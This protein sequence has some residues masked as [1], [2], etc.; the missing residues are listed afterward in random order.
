[1][2]ADFLNRRIIVKK[3]TKTGMKKRWSS[4]ATIDGD[5]Q[6]DEDRERQQAGA[7]YQERFLGFFDISDVGLL[8]QGRLL[9]DKLT[10]T[11]YTIDFAMAQRHP[12]TGTEYVEVTLVRNRSKADGSKNVITA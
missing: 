12:I 11:E 3:L 8:Q 2:I 7:E 6:N 9:T 4:T 1:M 10:D 5:I